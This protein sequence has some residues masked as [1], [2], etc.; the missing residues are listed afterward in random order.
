MIKPIIFHG[1]IVFQ[2]TCDICGRV[3]YL[4]ETLHHVRKRCRSYV[5]AEPLYLDLNPLLIVITEHWTGD[6]RIDI[7]ETCFRKHMSK[8]KYSTRNHQMCMYTEDQEAYK[9][10]FKRPVS[11]ET[12]RFWRRMND[13]LKD[14]KNM[15]I[16]VDT[17]SDDFVNSLPSLDPIEIGKEKNQC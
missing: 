12:V 14:A 4:E 5:K 3:I 17:F 10:R 13:A 15:H 16:P 2:K 9:G 7:C 8:F 11:L 1:R 6:K